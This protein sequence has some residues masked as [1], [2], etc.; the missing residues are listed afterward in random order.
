MAVEPLNAPARSDYWA[1]IRRPGTKSS[2]RAAGSGRHVTEILPPCRRGAKKPRKTV[3]PARPVCSGHGPDGRD[4]R[5][6][7]E[8]VVAAR[9]VGKHPEDGEPIMAQ[10]GRYGPTTHGKDSR[11]LP[12]EPSIFNCTVEQALEL[13]AQPKRGR[14]RQEPQPGKEIGTDPI[15]GKRS[16]SK[17]GRFGP[18]VTDGEMNASLRVADDPLTITLERASDL[19][20]ERR[21][22]G[23]APKKPRKAGGLRK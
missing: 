14:G 3:K 11:S 17:E 19:I 4:P 16:N 9:E 23:P 15:S 7:T 18:Y 5:R 1:S 10:N 21:A 6:R 12:D 8:V 2:R 20:S 13:F 22:K